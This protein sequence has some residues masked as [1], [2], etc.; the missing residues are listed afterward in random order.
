MNTLNPLEIIDYFYAEN[1]RLKEI[2]VKHSRAVADKALAISKNHPEL[3]LDNDFLEE[4]AM[5][6]DIGIIKTNAPEIFCFGDRPYICHGYL[7]AEMMRKLGYGRHA[8]VCERHTGAGLTKEDVE[9][10]LLPLPVKD[11]MPETNE[12]IVICVADKF[13]SKTKLNK[14]KTLDQAMASV[15]K[16]G[17]EGLAR[18]KTWCKA[19]L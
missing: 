3:M 6:H 16:H 14:E 11:F 19:L 8:R 2:L 18:F 17:E 5:L 10:K 4:A 1:P 13:F 9:R 15:A 7:G 12:E